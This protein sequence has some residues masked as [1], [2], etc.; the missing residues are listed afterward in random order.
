MEEKMENDLDTLDSVTLSNHVNVMMDLLTQDPEQRKYFIDL[1]IEKTA[2]V[3]KLEAQ[4]EKLVVSD[5]KELLSNKR[6]VV[7]LQKE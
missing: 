5:N 7:Q 3:E 4:I 6:K 1:L 2:A